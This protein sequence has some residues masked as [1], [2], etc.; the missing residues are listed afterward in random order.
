MN[1][2]I[3]N[4][5]KNSER[6]KKMCELFSFGDTDFLDEKAK[7]IFRKFNEYLGTE[8]DYFN[9]RCHFGYSGLC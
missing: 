3:W 8:E 6:G 4:L 7:Q 1:K 2:N 5:Y 9:D